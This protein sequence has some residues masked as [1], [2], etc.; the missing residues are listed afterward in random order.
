MLGWQRAE[1]AVALHCVAL[2]E[3]GQMYMVLI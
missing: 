2:D 1:I 3:R